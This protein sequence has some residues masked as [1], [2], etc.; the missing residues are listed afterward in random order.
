MSDRKKSYSERG[1]AHTTRITH[2]MV[3]LA[4]FI[5]SMTGY[6][7]LMVHP[8]LYWGEVGN[9]LTE[10]FMELPI[11]RNYQHGG[12]AE[13]VPFDDTGVSPVSRVRDY[14][15]FNQNGW[16]RSLHF[17][18]A[19][20]LVIAG[21]V[22]L[23]HGTISGHFRHHLLASVHPR[24]ARGL[25]QDLKNHMALKIRP[26]SGGP[27]YGCLQKLTYLV[28]VF[29]MM[30]LAVVTGFAMSPAITAEYPFLSDMFGGFQSARTIHFFVSVALVLFV[31][32]HVLMVVM[33]GFRAQIR[34]MTV[35][36]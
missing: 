19:W 18:G 10:A 28:V 12:W 8:R 34:A 17:L 35:G 24:T 31:I 11:S 13:P 9:A 27:Q 1:H 5:L 3:A 32:I 30:P 26:A 33:S 2:W 20:L 4:F 6:L 7:I 16:A 15:I 21:L 14:E 36:K 29:I 25:L 22:Y 23:L